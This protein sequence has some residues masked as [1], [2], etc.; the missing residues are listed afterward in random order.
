MVNQL[1]YSTV[2]DNF[3]RLCKFFNC[4]VG[5]IAEFISGDEQQ[6]DS[7]NSKS[8]KAAVKFARS[9]RPLEFLVTP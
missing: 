1:G 6:K 7:P 5:N 4:T 9:G 2:T 8:R 3:D